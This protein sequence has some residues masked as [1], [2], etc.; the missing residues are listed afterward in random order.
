MIKEEKQPV[1]VME[2]PIVFMACIS[3]FCFL[4]LLFNSVFIKNNYPF[5]YPFCLFVKT[6][7]GRFMLCV[8]FSL[9]ICAKK[10]VW[11]VKAL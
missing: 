2:Q 6:N 11:L 9:L 3:F 5:I 10:F 4:L 1:D 8:F 7:R